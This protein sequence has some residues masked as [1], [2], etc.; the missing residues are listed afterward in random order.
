M[1]ETVVSVIAPGDSGRLDCCDED[2]AHVWVR[3]LVWSPRR[4]FLTGAA[5]FVAA[6]GV[7]A[8]ELTGRRFV[9]DLDLAAPPEDD[10]VAERLRW[11]GLRPAST[12]PAQGDVVPAVTAASLLPSGG[13]EMDPERARRLLAALAPG[14]GVADAAVFTM[15]G[16]PASKARHRTGKD[17]RT[18]KTDADA[19]AERATGWRL[20]QQFR[21]PWTGNL[22]LGAVFF[23][24][25]RRSIDADNMLKHICDAGNKIAWAD[26]AQ[27]TATYGV[28]ELDAA[29]PRTLVVVARHVSSMARTAG[30][31]R[32]GTAR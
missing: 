11:P 3:V 2:D 4:A 17:G 15:P 29:H 6:A 14:V 25:D 23:R 21:Q 10:D 24:P 27:I 32:R 30:P 1:T 20:R 5:P 28:V 7:P 19:D 26:D 9:A 31:R 13:P 22:A 18:Y 16:V 12:V 8:A